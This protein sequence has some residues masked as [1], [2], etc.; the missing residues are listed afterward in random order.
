[1]VNRGVAQ[2]RSNSS[3][4]VFCIR[5]EHSVHANTTG[6]STQATYGDDAH[7]NLHFLHLH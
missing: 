4:N 6:L 7:L 1:M 2:I 5:V 3:E